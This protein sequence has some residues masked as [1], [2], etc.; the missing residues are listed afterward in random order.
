MLFPVRSLPPMPPTILTPSLLLPKPQPS[1][2]N[3]NYNDYTWR[4][5]IYQTP[6]HVLHT[7][8]KFCDA[9]L[10][11]CSKYA[12]VGISKDGDVMAMG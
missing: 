9:V 7:H 4:F 3:Y 11:L 5:T 2:L 10:L 6:S 12:L 1:S 8:C